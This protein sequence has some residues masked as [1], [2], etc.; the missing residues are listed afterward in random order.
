MTSLQHPMLLPSLD[1]RLAANWLQYF[2]SAPPPTCVIPAP[3]LGL[4]IHMICSFFHYFM[5]IPT[6]KFRNKTY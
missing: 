3:L 2:E 5:Q 1:N 4:E 6:R